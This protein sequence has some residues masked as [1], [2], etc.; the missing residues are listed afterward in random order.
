MKLTLK[1]NKI[2]AIALL[3]CQFLAQTSEELDGKNK[4][5][6]SLTAA[7]ASAVLQ[8]IAHKRNPDGTEAPAPRDPAAK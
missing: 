6:I 7:A 5:V 2:F 3:A 8:V 4:S 1:K